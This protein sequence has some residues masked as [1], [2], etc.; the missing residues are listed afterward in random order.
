MTSSV[1][2]VLTHNEWRVQVPTEWWKGKWHGDIEAACHAWKRALDSERMCGLR[3]NDCFELEV[4]GGSGEP[5]WLFS[6]FTT[7]IGPNYR[8]VEN[9]MQVFDVG[10]GQKRE[11]K[12]HHGIHL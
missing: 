3:F 5:G 6:S 9:A 2:D 8:Y 7:C 12:C 4:P 1:A 11:V 10:K